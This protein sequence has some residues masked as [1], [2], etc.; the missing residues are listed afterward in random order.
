MLSIAHLIDSFLPIT[1]GW[2]YNDIKLN[3]GCRNMVLCQYLQNT[4]VF[5]CNDIYP[6]F[7]SYSFAAVIDTLVARARARY[8][9]G[10]Y[11]VVINREKPDLLHGHF[12]PI[13]WRHIEL[14]KK[15]G[16]PL[17]TTFYGNDVDKLWQK[18][19]WHKRYQELFKTGRVFICE[20]PHMAS[21]VKSFGCPEEKIRII[22]HSADLQRIQLYI[23]EKDAG[24]IKVVF[25][26]LSRYKKG[27]EDAVRAFINIAGSIPELELHLIGDGLYR[28]TTYQ[29]L[30]TARL[31]NRVYYHGYLG[32]DAYLSLLG[33]SDIV[34]A[35][36]KTAP[37]FD[38]EGGA[39]VTVIEALTAGVPVVA[40]THCDIPY[41]VTHGETGLLC[42]E[43]DVSALSQNL[44]LLAG[45]KKTR[46]TMG[47]NCRETGRL[48][49]DVN[50]RL[51]KLLDV[52]QDVLLR[53]R[54]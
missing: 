23:K 13:S 54:Y 15:T 40:T 27:A 21:R 45:N 3:T 37:N 42:A 18:P 4:G 35:P 20:G 17:I 49:F 50:V 53:Y 1:Q 52:Y 51:Q 44:A 12:A 11:Q 29:M 34:L 2:M 9:T 39:P 36:S 25:V 22:N 10:P 30:A 47:D 16:L 24:R 5:P 6:L 33:Q 19:V 8:R 38:T 32:T 28:K 14:V 46:K 48:R 43:G 26:G 31:L 7:K 41:I